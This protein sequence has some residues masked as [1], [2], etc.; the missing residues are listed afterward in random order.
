MFA[1]TAVDSQHCH[2]QDRDNAKGNEPHDPLV[3]GVAGSNVSNAAQEDANGRPMSDRHNA[4]HDDENKCID[5]WPMD[6]HD[7][8][9]FLGLGATGAACPGTALKVARRIS[10]AAPRGQTITL[11]FASVW[12]H[13]RNCRRQA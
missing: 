4:G 1:V 8:V 7:Q 3:A 5:V 12:G 2:E 10:S 13:R 6:T 11:S 9:S